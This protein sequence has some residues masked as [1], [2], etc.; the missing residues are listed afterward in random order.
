MSVAKRRSKG[1]NLGL[2]SGIQTCGLK[3]LLVLFQELYGIPAEAGFVYTALDC[4]FD[5]D[6]CLFNIIG[7]RNYLGSLGCTCCREHC[8]YSIVNAIALQ[9]RNGDEG[10][11]KGS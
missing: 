5:E 4:L 11:A 8:L 6:N 10:T 9:G 7:E 3:Y 2:Y 1:I